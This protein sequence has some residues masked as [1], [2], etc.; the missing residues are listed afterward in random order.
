M[1]KP[2]NLTPYIKSFRNKSIQHYDK[3][4]EALKKGLKHTAELE[5][6]KSE[7]AINIANDLARKAPEEKESLG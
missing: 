7:V 6:S 4:Q 3:Y 2:E 1:E 5:R